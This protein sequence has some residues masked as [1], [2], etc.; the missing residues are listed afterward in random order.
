VREEVSFS[1]GH[2]GDYIVYT[3][4]LDLYDFDNIRASFL[5]VLGDQASI[6]LDTLRR[7]ALRASTNLVYANGQTTRALVASTNAKIV[8]G[9][10]K[11]IGVKL[12]NQRA[13]KFKR[14]VTGT[15]AVGTT[16]IRSAYLSIVSPEI[17]EDLRLLEKWKNVEDYADYSKAISED[18]VGS[19]GDFRFLESTNNAPIDVSGT[20]V[21]QSYFFGENAYTTVT[22]RGKQ[23]IQTKV[24]PL[25]SAGSADPLDQYGMMMKRNVSLYL[26]A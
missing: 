23:G 16:P 10:L 8:V 20:N 22:V 4:E 5:D 9:D 11:L 1:V 12:K 21:Y 25:G 6:T 14:V 24:K 15:T 13:K 17:T 18:E 26:A 2:Y 7:N 3:D 19:W